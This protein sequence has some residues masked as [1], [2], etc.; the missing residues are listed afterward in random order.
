MAVNKNDPAVR[1]AVFQAHSR[2][3]EILDALV[4]DETVEAVSIALD[5]A[6]DSLPPPKLFKFCIGQRVFAKETRGKGE[7][8]IVKQQWFA[9]KTSEPLYAV[10]MDGTTYV[11]PEKALEAID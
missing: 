2:K 11:F 8:G 4:N 10:V 7:H 1:A 5:V 9:Y 6:L 3:S